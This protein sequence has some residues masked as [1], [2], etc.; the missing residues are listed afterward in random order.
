[1]IAS[2][3]SAIYLLFGKSPAKGETAVFF[4]ARFDETGTD[5]Q[6]SHVI[7]AGGVSPP[8]AWDELER[9]WDRLMENRNVGIFHYR[10]FDAKDGDFANW[11]KLKKSN[12][13]NAIEKIIDKAVG[14]QV[15]IAVDREVHTQIKGEMRGIKGF[16]ADSDV[17]LCFRIA[18]F[19]VCHQIASQH[20]D[21]K[22][23]FIVED[24][25]YAADMHAIYQDIKETEGAKYTPAMHAEMLAGFSSIPKGQLRSLEAADYL[26]G[27]GIADLKKGRFLRPGRKK[28]T[29]MI[30]DAA[31]LRGWHTGMLE[32]RQRRQVHGRR[33]TM[34]PALSSDPSV[35]E[36]S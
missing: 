9:L 18:R 26:A 14:F 11:G 23:K 19:Y 10:D 30:A 4:S 32:E 2:I 28:Q 12:F 7:V 24:G 3:G 21:A 8:D 25:P 20:P 36:S 27:R 31:F 22:I 34:N 15:A 1:M 16:K 6:S 29:S 5:G 17:G 35:E 13:I 33:R